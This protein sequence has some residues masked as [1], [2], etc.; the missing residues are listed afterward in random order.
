MEREGY[1]YFFRLFVHAQRDKVRSRFG[2]PPIPYPLPGY[3]VP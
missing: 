1:G 2:F 3:Q